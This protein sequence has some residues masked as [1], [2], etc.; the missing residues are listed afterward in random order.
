MTGARR[1]LPL[2][3]ALGVVILAHQ[4]VDLWPMIAGTDFATPAGRLRLFTTV[5]PRVAAFFT[6][7]VLLV[8]AAVRLGRA[9]AVRTL[10]WTHLLLG[11]LLW[12]AV[13]FFLADAGRMAAAIA[14]PDLRGYRVLVSRVLG[15][16]L[17]SGVAGLLAGRRL[18]QLVPDLTLAR[19]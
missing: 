6:A 18:L 10:G 4:V 7:D 14:G 9:G 12:V 8:W 16:L 19:S 1:F 3:G 15:V 11:V 5:S 13:P 2:L 17:L